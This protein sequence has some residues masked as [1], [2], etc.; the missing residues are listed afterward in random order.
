MNLGY[1][2]Y[3][4][5]EVSLMEAIQSVMGDFLVALAS[6]FTMFGDKLV[7]VAILSFLYWSYNK[8]VAQR[9]TLNV[10]LA[11]TW[12]PMI[13]NVVFRRRPY[14][15]NPNIKC[16]KAVEPEY[17]IYDIEAQGFSFPSAHS[18]CASVCYPGLAYYFKKTWLWII[19]IILPIIVCV[20]RFCLGVH[21]PTDTF[22]GLIFGVIM[23]I[24][25]PILYDKFFDKD[26]FIIV[27]LLTTVPGLF[28]CK[29]SDYFSGFGM[30]LGFCAG[31]L[32]E[33]RFVNF[34]D[35][36]NVK[37][38]ILRTAVGLCVF[39]AIAQGPKLFLPDELYI[40]VIRYSIA[41][42]I[43]MGVY[44]MAFKKFENKEKVKE[45]K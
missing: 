31:V 34:E 8:K 30:V 22:V 5:W 11:I 25:T 41:T 39:L 12:A 40:R 23:C 10:L 2:F 14:F 18:L 45:N 21:Y 32:F 28:Y 33:R 44:P 43:A 15:D 20:S 7:P 42:F 16:L 36:R 6:F 38:M 13:K 35:P 1:T 27:V 9:L 17:D 4:D 26:W 24:V 3:F 19:G 37:Y 29:T